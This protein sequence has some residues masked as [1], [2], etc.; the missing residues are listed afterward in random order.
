MSIASNYQTKTK[1]NMQSVEDPESF[2]SVTER[3]TENVLDLTLAHE[4]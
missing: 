4:I 1:R 3:T 2:C